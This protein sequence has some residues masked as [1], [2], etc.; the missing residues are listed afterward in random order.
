MAARGLAAVHQRDGDIR[1]GQQSVREGEATGASSH[2]EIVSIHSP[3]LD[4]LSAG[5][6]ARPPVSVPKEDIPTGRYP[7]SGHRAGCECHHPKR[8]E[9]GAPWPPAD[10][11]LR[12]GAP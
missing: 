2:Y 3:C 11:S 8:P 6:T 12:R 1:F 4:V 9:T 5:S 10:S 7:S